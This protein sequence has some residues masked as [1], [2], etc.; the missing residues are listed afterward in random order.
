MTTAILTPIECRSLQ[1]LSFY[2]KDD[3]IR[4]R[5]AFGYKAGWEY[6]VL[7]RISA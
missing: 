6:H 1:W 4:V 5:D 3:L 2:E 7:R